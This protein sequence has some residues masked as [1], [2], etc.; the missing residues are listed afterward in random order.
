MS[1]GEGRGRVLRDNQRGATPVGLPGSR[2]VMITGAARGLGRSHAREFA[3]DGANL[4][5]VDICRDQAPTP[6]PMASRRQLEETALECERLGSRVVTA[7]ADVRKQNELDEAVAAGVSELGRIDVLVN[8]AGLL[9]PGGRPTH[10]ITE[11]EW[12]LVL[13][14]NLNGMWRAAKAVLPHMIEQRS[15]CIINIASTAGVVGFALFSSYVASKHAVIGLTKAMALEYGRYDVRVNA[16]CPSTLRAEATLESTSTAAVAELV[17][18]DLEDY[19]ASSRSFQA[20]GDLV[21]ARDVSQACVW[22]A[23]GSASMLT[24]AAIPIDAGYLAR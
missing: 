5:L 17:G 11:P 7:V 14:V 2:V 19:E 12:L 20:L 4:I 13:D 24:G 23:G 16:L 15:G 1:A 22:L 21:T 3:K 18:A 10:E 6:Y 8:N 9:G